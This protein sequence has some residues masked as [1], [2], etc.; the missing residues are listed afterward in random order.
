[1]RV[2]TAVLSLAAFLSGFPAAAQHRL[3]ERDWNPR[4]Q[5][6][7]ANG[8]GMVSRGEWAGNRRS[9]NQYDQNG[10]GV[11]SGFEL[12]AQQ[13][14]RPDTS[15]GADR[16]A[17]FNNLD[18]SNNGL[19]E[20]REW[21]YDRASFRQFDVNNDGRLSEQEY[22]GNAP[23]YG[24]DQRFRRWDRNGNGYLESTEWK[25]DTQVFHRLDRDEDSRV[26]H[27]EFIS[28]D[29]DFLTRSLDTNGDGVINR[30]EWHGA[31]AEFRALDVNGDSTIT[32]DELF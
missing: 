21:P 31:G 12:M 15:F 8:D 13:P 30:N 18:R 23:A 16:F 19:I 10:D 17:A 2:R 25:S 28:A 24:N 3:S 9:F 6:L 7:D 1:M 22:A 14:A 32:S 4:F 5:G 29:R 26:S 27:D 20:R 11:I